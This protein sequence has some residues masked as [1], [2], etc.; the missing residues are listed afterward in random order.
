MNDNFDGINFSCHEN[1]RGI[2]LA[3]FGDF[4]L[5][6][7]TNYDEYKPGLGLGA[8]FSYY[9]E[10]NPKLTITVYIYNNN[11]WIIPDGIE[12]PLVDQE[13]ANA[14]DSVREFYPDMDVIDSGGRQ[15]ILVP[16]MPPFWWAKIKIDNNISEV[17]LTGL[18]NHFF[19]MRITHPDSDEFDYDK[20]RFT[21]GFIHILAINLDE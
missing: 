11:E 12:T 16:E 4:K 13:A 21:A 10:G 19:K 3:S 18:K 8:S 1:V 2:T 15:S 20:N 5:G 14:I 17:Y 9:F 7:Y 6:G